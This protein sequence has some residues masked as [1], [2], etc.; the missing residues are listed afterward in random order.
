MRGAGEG[1]DAEGAGARVAES[2]DWPKDDRM[3]LER[4]DPLQLD[5]ATSERL[6]EV[7]NDSARAAGQSMAP[8]T[9]A[10]LAAQA[11]YTHDDRPFDAMWLARERGDVVAMASIEF[12]RW[13]NQHLAMAFCTVAPEVQGR[14]IGTALLAEQKRCCQAERRSL[15]LTFC[16]RDTPGHR[17][18]TESGFEVGQANAQRRLYP[19]R[20]DYG[21][22]RS[23]ADDASG[24]AADYEIVRLDGPAPHEW[25]P[26]LVSLFE[27]INDAPNDE[28]NATPDIFSVERIRQYESA[29]AHR[30]QHLYRLMARHKDSGEWA[31]HSILCVDELRP[32][33]A[34]QEDTTVVPRHRGHRL[35]IWLKA[36]MLLW[37]RELRRELE[38]IDTWNAE[39]NAHMIAVNDELGCVV[40]A[41]GFVLQLHL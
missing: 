34:M 12:P 41:R 25:L 36:A 8:M 30:S 13:D 24:R 32:G 10:S 38:T 11:R 17:L 1:R 4:V 15:L 14:G 18:L 33:V 26:A 28:I 37:M 29:M 3:H 7:M 5:H 9:A 2:G 6:A 22:L 16:N 27:A 35:G 39:S 19:Q 40:N 21:N 20:I 31:G 23:L